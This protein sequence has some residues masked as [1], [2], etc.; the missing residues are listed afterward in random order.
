MEN[1]RKH[2]GINLVKSRDE[3]PFLKELIALEIVKTEIKMN[4]PVYS[5]QALLDQGK[6]SVYKFHYLCMQPKYGSK[7]KLCYMDTGSFMYEIETKNFN[8]DIA[9]D[10]ET[11]FDTSGYSKDD[12]RPLPMGRNRKAIGMMEDEFGEE[13]MTDFLLLRAKKAYEYRKL[14]KKLEDK[15]CKGSKI[16]LVAENLLLMAIKTSLLKGEKLTESKYCLRARN[17]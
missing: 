11:N 6:T 4:K 12:K 14:D 16:G 17:T 10:V 2:K 9:K 1:I 8:R 15:R 7:M 5:G 13:I 3:H